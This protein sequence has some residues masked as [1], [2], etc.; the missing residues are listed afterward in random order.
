MQNNLKSSADQKSVGAGKTYHLVLAGNQNQFKDFLLQ[1]GIP[2]NRAKFIRDRFDV[3]G[4]TKEY[5]EIQRVG[6]WWIHP[7]LDE[8]ESAITSMH[9]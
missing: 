7:K 2:P 5:A 8:I 3:Y 6:T 9:S 4:F 1:T